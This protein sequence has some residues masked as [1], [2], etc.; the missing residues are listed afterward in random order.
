MGVSATPSSNSILSHALVQCAE[1][2]PVKELK[3]S[4][5]CARG[6]GS[7]WPPEGRDVIGQDWGIELADLALEQLSIPLGFHLVAVFLDVLGKLVEDRDQV[8]G[9]SILVALG[10]RVDVAV[11]AKGLGEFLEG[12]EQVNAFLGGLGRL[13]KGSTD[14]VPHPG[15]E[16]VVVVQRLR[17]WLVSCHGFAPSLHGFVIVSALITDVFHTVN[18]LPQ[19]EAILVHE[20]AL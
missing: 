12:H 7:T 3:P 10:G 1:F 2:S 18:A 9:S 6:R 5:V 20:A 4:T 14:E 8:G 13:A 17:A 15:V 11:V 16:L 19:L